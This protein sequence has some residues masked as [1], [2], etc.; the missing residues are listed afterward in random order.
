MSAS[1]LRKSYNLL[2]ASMTFYTHV[3]SKCTISKAN[4]ADMRG[5]KLK[6]SY[7]RLTFY[8]DANLSKEPRPLGRGLCF[9][10]IGSSLALQ[11][12]MRT[13]PLPY[14]APYSITTY[15]SPLA[16]MISEMLLAPALLLLFLKIDDT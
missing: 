1:C 3:T 6:Y 4:C 10:M 11:C 2:L 5:I 13:S 14:I 9:Y 12:L 15:F 7:Y 16:R 8:N